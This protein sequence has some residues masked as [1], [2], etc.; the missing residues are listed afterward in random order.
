MN[1]ILFTA[2]AVV[3]LGALTSGFSEH[4]PEEVQKVP[5][6]FEL[7]KEVLINTG[8]PAE[9][10]YKIARFEDGNIVGLDLSV[11]K[12]M[13]VHT[14][15]D[16][17]NTYEDVYRFKPFNTLPAAIGELTT[18]RTLNLDGNSLTSLPE[19]IGQ[20]TNLKVLT[21]KNN[22]LRSLP[23]SIANLE[24]LE[25]LDVRHNKIGTLSDGV[26]NL[27]LLKSLHL[28]GN[29]I[30]SLPNSIMTLRLKHFDI[31][32]ADLRRAPMEIAQWVKANSDE[33]YH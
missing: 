1:K 16:D 25:V 6:D 3:A 8:R 4:N 9:A 24:H 31:D 7:I 13:I 2:V 17:V 15:D 20:L 29:K 23:A 30:K 5:N 21:V 14:D 22:W 10:I 33:Y 26:G 27:V 28:S 12:K 19:Q 32:H 18:L 11:D